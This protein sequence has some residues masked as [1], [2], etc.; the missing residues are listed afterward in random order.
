MQGYNDKLGSELDR[1]VAL[2]AQKA[3]EMLRVLN[4][5][6]QPTIQ[7]NFVQPGTGG[8]AT[9]QQQSSLGSTSNRFNQTIVSP[10]SMHAA[11]QSRREIQKAQA[12]TLYDTGRRLA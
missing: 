10:N 3:A 9:G 7:P 5:T 11:R 2:A 12:R 1:A 4:F 6:A 8:A